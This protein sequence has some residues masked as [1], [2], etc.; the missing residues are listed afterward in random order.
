MLPNFTSLGRQTHSTGTVRNMSFNIH[1]LNISHQQFD[2]TLLITH[3]S[4]KF[5]EDR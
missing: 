5:F 2:D 4:W 1:C 3:I